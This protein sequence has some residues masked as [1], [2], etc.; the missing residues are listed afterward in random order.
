MSDQVLVAGAAL[1]AFGSFFLGYGLG[2]GQC[3]GWRDQLDLEI[4]E[5]E[6]RTALLYAI[7]GRAPARERRA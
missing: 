3:N 4:D 2:W 1:I 6:R 5:T 7:S